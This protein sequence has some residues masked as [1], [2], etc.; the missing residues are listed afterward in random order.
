MKEPHKLVRVTM[1]ALEVMHLSVSARERDGIL[2]MLYDSSHQAPI[3]WVG[4][5]TANAPVP[6]LQIC[7][8][9]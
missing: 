1:R 8:T 7:R 6:A 3:K 9:G 4:I 2:L 5:N